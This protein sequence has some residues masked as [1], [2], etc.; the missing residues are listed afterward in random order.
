[1]LSGDSTA[2]GQQREFVKGCLYKPENAL[3]EAR[4]FYE[5]ITLNLIRKYSR[6]LGD[7]YQVDV[8]RE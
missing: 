1:M 2:N 7:S 4:K 5:A 6:K 3:D 8:V